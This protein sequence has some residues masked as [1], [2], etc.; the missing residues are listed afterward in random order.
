VRIE[1]TNTIDDIAAFH[2]FHL[3]HSPYLRRTQMLL[4]FVF[5]YLFII[6]TAV[7]FVSSGRLTSANYAI[8]IVSLVWILVIPPFYKHSAKSA[9]RKVYSEGPSRALFTKHVLTV[10]SEGIH[11]ETAHSSTLIGWPALNETEE[12]RGRIY[13]YYSSGDAFMVPHSAFQSAAEKEEFV[14]TVEGFIQSQADQPSGGSEQ[15]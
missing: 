2:A 8:L 11:D 5:P 14:K 10:S 6:L 15:P 12:D 1:Y 13:V 9:A 4:R 3:E 7:S